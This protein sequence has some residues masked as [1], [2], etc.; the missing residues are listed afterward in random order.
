[1]R[2]LTIAAV[3][4]T[5]TA[6]VADFAGYPWAASVKTYNVPS[7]FH[8]A[9]QVF[10]GVQERAYAVGD[11]GINLVQTWTV[12]AGSTTEVRDAILVYPF[13][14]PDYVGWYEHAGSD[15][16]GAV[17][18]NRWTG[19]SLFSGAVVG[20]E[21]LILG[22]YDW[23]GPSLY[24]YTNSVGSPSV[25]NAWATNWQDAIYG[26]HIGGRSTGYAGRLTNT[27]ALTTNVVTTNAVAPFLYTAV[28]GVTRTGLPWVTHALVAA[29]D[30]KLQG[31]VG[32]F[33]PTNLPGGLGQYMASTTGTNVNE[34]TNVAA[35]AF[36]KYSLEG[37]IAD[38]GVGYSTNVVTNWGGHIT[39]AVGIFSRQTTSGPTLLAEVSTWQTGTGAL[40]T[41]TTNA[42]YYGQ[43][44]ISGDGVLAPH[45]LPAIYPVIRMT[46]PTA[47][48]NAGSTGIIYTITG[49]RIATNGT[50]QAVVSA[51]E[52]GDGTYTGGTLT[53]TQLWATVTNLDLGGYQLPSG[54][55]V[56]IIYTNPITT[57]G[58]IMPYA[59]YARDFDERAAVL[60][61]MTTIEAG[62]PGWGVPLHGTGVPYSA[63]YGF[64]T[65]QVSMA[66][67]F[68][69]AQSGIYGKPLE[70]NR[71]EPHALSYGLIEDNFST[72]GDGSTNFNYVYS[73]TVAEQRPARGV[74]VRVW[75]NMPSFKTAA[76]V[77][78]DY[79]LQ[80]GMYGGTGFSF[81]S[82]DYGNRI[83]SNM[84]SAT[85]PS[86]T[87][88]HPSLDANTQT[89]Y[90]PLLG[91]NAPVTT[92]LYWGWEDANPGVQ[93]NTPVTFYEPYN[94]N[95][96]FTL[97]FGSIWPIGTKVLDRQKAW[98]EYDF[99]WK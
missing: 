21:G 31:I 12:P 41:V 68:A 17:F 28:D 51:Y 77:Y 43:D 76:A 99:R 48:T 83:R 50:T 84:W 97:G 15:T 81:T 46:D 7:N 24:A 78:C 87:N 79:G 19:K 22:E 23:I 8:A 54:R 33:I 57:Y 90:A 91:T 67:A 69:A 53:L 89:C 64:G 58:N 3:L 32:N 66:A 85:Y 88:W 65:S 10:S 49:N 20:Q 42:S 93:S 13:A 74:A 14:D 40:H 37:A 35:R 92:N 56:S 25:T 29:I 18:S 1:M 96:D 60:S 95:S 55:T 44:D 45:Y 72:N 75:S 63:W 98:L 86:D 71:L 9:S 82:S 5:A 34:D 39:N 36:P 61:L 52:I 2:A 26:G 30:S 6:A 4:L 11:A 16:Y 38:A 73:V 94:T 59:F 70:A 27:L 62:T 80:V 47:W